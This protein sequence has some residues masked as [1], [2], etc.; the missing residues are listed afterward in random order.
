VAA[1]VRSR[2]ETHAIPIIAVT[3]DALADTQ[4]RARA[5]GC[6]AYL[7]KPIDLAVLMTTMDAVTRT[8]A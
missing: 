2:V 3:A 8:P 6:D 4:E 1:E 5:S 7:T